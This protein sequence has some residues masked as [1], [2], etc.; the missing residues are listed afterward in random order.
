MKD[1]CFKRFPH[2]D[3]PERNACSQFCP[4]ALSPCSLAESGPCKP[5]EQGGSPAQL[6]FLY[7]FVQI[8]C[9]CNL[10][11]FNL[12]EF[13]QVLQFRLWLATEYSHWILCNFNSRMTWNNTFWSQTNIISDKAK[14]KKIQFHYLETSSQKACSHSLS[15]LCGIFGHEL[16]FL[17]FSLLMWILVHLPTVDLAHLLC[18]LSF[19]LWH[20]WGNFLSWYF[21][22]PSS[23]YLLQNCVK[24][25]KILYEKVG[26]QLE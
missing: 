3:L 6:H 20:F 25:K 26:I 12:N 14:S 13:L 7:I 24:L 15:H 17:H 8:F 21:P 10:R 23:Q 19:H 5:L 16:W 11:I 2:L 22:P 18:P 4:P 1:A 9:N